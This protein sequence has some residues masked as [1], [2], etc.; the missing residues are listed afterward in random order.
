MIAVAVSLR[1]QIG[2]RT[3]MAVQR[4]LIRVPLSLDEALAGRLPMLPPLHRAAHG[5]A[6]TSLPADRRSAM[7]FAGGGMIAFVRQRYTRH[8]ID[9]R[10]ALMPISTGFRPTPDQA[11]AARPAS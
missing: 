4:Q 6:I 9:L 1:F 11:C 2:A 5:Y 7:A 10:G 3:L 8:F